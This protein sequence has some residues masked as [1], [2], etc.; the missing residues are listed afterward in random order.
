MKERKYIF[1]LT[2]ICIYIFWG[3]QMIMKGFAFDSSDTI[4]KIGIIIIIPI[5]LV[6]IINDKYT[7]RELILCLILLMIAILD[8]YY[9]KNNT[10]MILALSIVAF[11]NIDKTILFRFSFF[12]RGCTY[13]L[14]LILCFIGILDIGYEAGERVRYTFGY[15]HANLAQGEI[16]AI[17]A[18]YFLSKNGKIKK[19]YS[20]FMIV[21]SYF[22]FLFTNSRTGFLSTILLLVFY[23]L[24]QTKWFQF[25]LKMFGRY[26]FI[27]LTIICFFL[28]NYYYAIQWITGF[29]TFSSRFQTAYFLERMYKITLFGQ[30]TTYVSDL[31]YVNLLY[32]YGIILFLLFIIG[33]TVLLYRFIKTERWHLVAYTL[34]LAIYFVMEGY[35]ISILYN[36]VWIYYTE[37]LFNKRKENKYNLY[38]KNEIKTSDL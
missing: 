24:A 36:S 25:I 33:H 8:Y 11:R 26:I 22:V 28:S 19:R 35:Q 2:E 27:F 37:L 12:T 9:S 34:V 38:R 32:K 14:H 29:G 1:S 3:F 21:I 23:Y 20:L 15:T 4:F 6:K 18:Y 5:I 10:F 17:L 31:G 30:A 16:F 7:L 13:L